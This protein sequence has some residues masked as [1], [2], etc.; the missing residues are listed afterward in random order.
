MRKRSLTSTTTGR[1]A[2]PSENQ[3]S[4]ALAR[5]LDVLRAFRAG[6][7][8]LGNQDIVLRT[9][10]PK[11][12]VSRITL[13]LSSL[14]YLA[15]DEELGRYSLGPATVS[16]GYTA[17]KG[18]AVVHM[19]RPLMQRLADRTGAAVAL[20]TRD[21]LEMLYLANC[22]SDSLVTLR[23]NPGS[24]I[25]VWQ[26]AMG[27]AY[28]MGLDEAECEAVLSRLAAARPGEEGAMRRAMEACAA[29]Y[30]ANGFC[31]SEG[32]W[33]SYVN[34]A[35]VPFRPADGSPVVAITCGGVSELLSGRALREEI[36]P[37]LVRLAAELEARLLGDVP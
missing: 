10:L 36:G 31:V 15:Y 14:G 23:L 21:E 26:T 18:S 3:V 29:F 20:G 1:P 37:A 32:L 12:T 17:L 11:A 2:R 24:R 28:L 19:A 16:L 4:T 27:Q 33:H 34:A 22:R 25:P 9:G 5:G 30:R 6:D 13:T 35:G 8:A 7:G